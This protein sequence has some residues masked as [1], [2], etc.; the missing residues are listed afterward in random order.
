MKLI[1]GALLMFSASAFATCPNLKG[2]Y[3]CQVD[4]QEWQDT[5]DQTDNPD[6]TVTYFL[7]GDT[8]ART[9]GAVRNIPETDDFR[10]GKTSA[11]CQDAKLAVA[12]NGDFWEEGTFRGSIALTIYSY[13]GNN[14]DWVMRQ[15]GSFQTPDGNNYPFDEI[16]SCRQL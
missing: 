2:T 6:G 16:L 8:Y 9:D 1:I 7:N 15:Q 3:H 4:D 14:G 12:V 13:R 10:N 5:F 11:T